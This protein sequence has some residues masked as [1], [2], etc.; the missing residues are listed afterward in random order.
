MKARSYTVAEAQRDFEKL[1]LEAEQGVEVYI[2]DE[3]KRMVQLVPFDQGK[4]RTPDNQ[5][6]L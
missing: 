2:V 5:Q 1:L 6:E 3:E 4:E